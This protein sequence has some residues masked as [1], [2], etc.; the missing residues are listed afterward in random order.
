V[1]Q[2]IILSPQHKYIALSPPQL[3]CL[4]IVH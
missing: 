3:E 2:A 1:S 4:Y